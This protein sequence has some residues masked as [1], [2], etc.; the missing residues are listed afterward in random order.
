MV[1]RAEDVLSAEATT[2]LEDLKEMLHGIQLS[3]NLHI[4]SFGRLK[5]KTIYGKILL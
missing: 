1:I 4:L 3:A 2:K 5:V